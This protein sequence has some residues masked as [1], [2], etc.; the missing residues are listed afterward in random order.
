MLV[1]SSALFAAWSI[2]F[3]GLYAVNHPLQNLFLTTLVDVA[4]SILKTTVYSRL[5]T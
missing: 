3:V 4:V 2:I 5:L 1:E